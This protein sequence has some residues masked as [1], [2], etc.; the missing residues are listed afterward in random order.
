MKTASA[1]WSSFLL[2]SIAYQTQC[3]KPAAEDKKVK[4]SDVPVLNLYRDQWT[5]A[6][7]SP[8]QPQLKCSN[9]F[10]LCG[11]YAPNAVQCY[12]K[13]NDG[14]DVQWECKAKLDK[15]VRFG[16]L[17][18]K[19][20]GYDSPDDQYVLVGSCGLEYSLE[21]TSR[22]GKNYNENFHRDLYEANK[23]SNFLTFLI[24]IVIML[25]VYKSCTKYHDQDPS[26]RHH[27]RP[28]FAN[29]YAPVGVAESANLHFPSVPTSASSSTFPP[30]PPPYAYVA[31]AIAAQPPNA[32]GF[33]PEY[34][35]LP[36]SPS[37]NTDGASQTSTPFTNANSQQPTTS[38]SSNVGWG[39]FLTGVGVGSVTGFLISRRNASPS[40]ECG[41]LGRRSGTDSP[42]PA[43]H[44]HQHTSNTAT[45]FA[46]TTRR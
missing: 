42:P 33:K 28:D 14:E 8:Q 31:A 7:R 37:P 5:T 19:C 29:I 11:P 30:P 38:S 18:V 32:P 43:Y 25:I 13:G 2:L 23:L 6:R 17:E 24:I 40:R 9:G 21:L 39:N 4:L 45:G 46:S 35:P 41:D 1:I 36:P 26:S 10:F 16:Y 27:F 22:S 44:E 20:E 12:N 3:D 15:R 34:M